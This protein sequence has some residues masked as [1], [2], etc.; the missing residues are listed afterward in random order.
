MEPSTHNTAGYAAGLG[1]GIAYG[2]Y[3]VNLLTLQGRILPDAQVGYCK[4]QLR[5]VSAAGNGECGEA[6]GT[7]TANV[8]RSAS[9]LMRLDG[10][11]TQASRFSSNRLNCIDHL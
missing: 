10:D 8:R 2:G 3:H 5:Q 6:S 9:S 4:R 11:G 1:A 7:T